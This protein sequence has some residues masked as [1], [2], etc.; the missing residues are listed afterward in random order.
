MKEREELELILKLIGDF[1]LPL[2]PILDYAIREKIDK[3]S[4][5][6]DILS[7][8]NQD[9]DDVS[10]IG[11]DAPTEET[12]RPSPH[13]D[14]EIIERSTI[15]FDFKI[16]NKTNQCF[17]INQK[18][19]R[20]YSGSGKLILLEDTFYRIFYNR[21][22]VSINH[23]DWND[24]KGKFQLGERIVYEQM[25]ST[26]Y[27]S[28]DRTQYLEQIKA[29][30]F[31]SVTGEYRV[32]VDN[33]WYRCISKKT[34][35]NESG[36]EKLSENSVSRIES[37]SCPPKNGFKCNLEIVENGQRSIAVIGSTK[38][39]KDFL[40]AMGGFFM[41][42]TQWGPAWIFSSSK[43]DRIQ[44]YINGGISNENFEAKVEKSEVESIVNDGKSL[45]KNTQAD[46]AKTKY[47][48]SD[49]EPLLLV[50]QQLD[51]DYSFNGKQQLSKR[52]FVLEVVKEYVRQHPRITYESLLKIFPA[53]L[54]YNKSNGV[55]KL[56]SD[57]IEKCSINPNCSNYFF[58][59]VKDII[60]LE[61]GVNVVVHSQW[62][63][64][65]DNFFKVARSLFGEDFFDQPI[66]NKT[67]PKPAI[68]E[69]TRL[70][71]AKAHNP[72]PKK[73]LEIKK[74][75]N[76]QQAH[77]NQ[78]SSRDR[79]IGYTIRILPSQEIA[80]IIGVRVDH[81][82]YKRLVIRTEDYHLKE[83][84]DNPYL[85]IILKRKK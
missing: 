60:V 1:N 36:S 20:A 83:I 22:A 6:T 30:K 48:S 54:N 11:L 38:M 78:G 57:V 53:S 64:D 68:M 81:E 72:S 61:N 51:K 2:S 49:S 62:G 27:N 42:H 9:E 25:G 55:I 24:K 73:E 71:R 17:I 23:I 43:R 56:Y 80:E 13:L 52:R 84:D 8:S 65:F 34:G 70:I 21:S 75:K 50:D 12:S 66:I 32:K 5:N 19:K 74:R 16:E 79:K 33:S 15:F 77:H 44:A 46:I 7:I 40:K 14:N 35:I 4:D 82:G 76:S 28:L 85:Y 37:L 29:I 26:L 18:G 47:G 58:L 45:E 63:K 69:K 10:N 39:H 59:D 3:Y 67:T 41:Y 31:D